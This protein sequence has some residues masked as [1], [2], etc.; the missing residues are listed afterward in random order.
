MSRVLITTVPFASIDRRPLDLLESAGI[1][2]VINPLGRKLKAT[3]LAELICGFDVVIAGTEEITESVINTADRLKLIS[4]VGVGLDGVDL[5][6]AE[7]RG[8]LV[9]YTPEAPAPAV[10]ELT[11]ALILNLLRNVHIA[12]SQMHNGNWNRLFGRRISEVTFGII[13]AGRIGSR[14]VRNLVSLGANRVL[15]NDLNALNDLNEDLLN[16]INYV[17]KD[18]IYRESDVLSIHIPL[19]ASTKNMIGYEQ[20]SLMKLDAMLIN[21]SRGGIVNENDLIKILLEGRLSGA[22]ID[23]FEQEP[24]QGGLSQIDRCILTSHMGS[25][26]TD[27]R[28]KMEVEATE[29]AIRY[30]TGMPLMGTVPKSEYENQRGF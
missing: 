11:L 14:V 30:L 22:A 1:E 4:R 29:E 26:S 7:K 18:I 13:G 20:L 10:A 3:E 17:D 21:T 19:N 27:C 2:Y 23:V 8:I 16:F 12:N 15:V 6:S 5:K 28:V 25:M 24:Y 9:S